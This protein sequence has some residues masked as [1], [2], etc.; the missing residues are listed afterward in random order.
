MNNEGGVADINKP[1]AIL[2]LGRIYRAPEA[3]AQAI[4]NSCD[5]QADYIWIIFDKIKDPKT[6][7]FTTKITIIDDGE[8][9]LP[10]MPDEDAKIFEELKSLLKGGGGKVTQEE[11]D[12]LKGQISMAARQSFIW[13]MESYAFSGKV[14]V[15]G[16]KQSRKVRGRLG[17]GSLSYYSYANQGIYISRPHPG[18]AKYLWENKS[19]NDIPTYKLMPPTVEKLSEYSSSYTVDEAEGELKDPWGKPMQYG[20]RLEITGMS[21]DIFNTSL[22]PG[23]VVKYL[24]Q[25]FSAQL[26][27]GVVITLIDNCTEKGMKKRGGIEHRISAL[28][29]VGK[30][31]YNKKRRLKGGRG[32][33]KVLI[34]YN[35]KKKSTLRMR[36]L[37]SDTMAI[38]RVPELNIEPY[39][40]G[41]LEGYIE[42]PDLLPDELPLDSSKKRPLS[43]TAYDQWVKIIR[44]LAPE[45]SEKIRGEESKRENAKLDKHGRTVVKAVLLA[46][47][48]MPV[49]E[50]IVFGRGSTVRRRRKPTDRS[51]NKVPSTAVTAVAIASDRKVRKGVAN[52]EFRLYRGQKLINEKITAHS[53]HVYFGSNLKAGNYTIKLAGLPSGMILSIGTHKCDFLISPVEPG[54]SAVFKIQTNEPIDPLKPPKKTEEF[55]PY[56]PELGDPNILYENQLHVGLVGVNKSNP[57]IAD[58]VE[59]GAW[60]ELNPYVA[61]AVSSSLTEHVMKD[62]YEPEFCLQQNAE[63]FVRTMDMLGK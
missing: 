44:S 43:S 45:I 37:G 3:I 29:Y 42:I 47:A 15:A 7:E 59:R 27:D 5:A 39:N 11:I 23:T 21:A 34:R 17:I 9:I 6:G 55:R 57:I 36:V 2:G 52:V 41:V 12:H 50:E 18:W 35:S 1:Q 19:E 13:M 32:E 62:D 30:M 46:A 28:T 54:F 60:R 49:F 4:E 24:S 14:P 40:K 48:E 63:L 61:L 58:M 31:I 56:Y 16:E 51:K 8:G 33:F 20:T 10:R 25:V 26:E 22:K 53:G 38:S